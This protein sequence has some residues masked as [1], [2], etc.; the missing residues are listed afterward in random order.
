M[1][2]VEECEERYQD[3]LDSCEGLN[4]EEY[5]MCVNECKSDYQ[6]C[7]KEYSEEEES[8]ELEEE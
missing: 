1:S 8:E 3:C 7:L 2:Y 4:D 5:E 6:A